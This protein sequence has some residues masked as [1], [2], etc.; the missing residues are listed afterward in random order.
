MTSGVTLGSVLTQV[1]FGS[2]TTVNSGA[3]EIDGVQTIKIT[4][5]LQPVDHLGTGMASMFVTAGD[6]PLPVEFSESGSDG[7]FSARF[8]DWGV[9][10]S[11]TAPVAA[12]PVASIP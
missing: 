6:H 8:S 3:S 2:A 5:Q 12:L 10:V 1:G 4:G 7:Q 9:P 11:L